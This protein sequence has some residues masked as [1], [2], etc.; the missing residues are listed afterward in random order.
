M[1]L[2]CNLSHEKLEALLN[3]S[4][5]TNLVMQKSDK[6]NSEVILDKDVFVKRIESPFS[7]KAKFEKYDTKKGLLKFTVN[8]EKRINE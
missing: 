2:P 3:L 7:D 1:D 5:N 6:G 4:N 8:H